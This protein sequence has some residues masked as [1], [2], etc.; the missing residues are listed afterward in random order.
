MTSAV[1]GA[2]SLLQT[3]AGGAHWPKRQSR[4]PGSFNDAVSKGDI[5]ITGDQAKVSDLLA[6]LDS[7]EFW[8]NIVTP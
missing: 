8:F 6:S 3:P 1:F 7:F 5:K 4:Q 2:S